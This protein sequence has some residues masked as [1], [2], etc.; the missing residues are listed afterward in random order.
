[1]CR[2]NKKILHGGNAL[3]KNI[4]WVDT[5]RVLASLLI[6]FAHFF[7]CDGFKPQLVLHN[8]SFDV[9]IIGVFL[10]FA[11]SGY[12]IPGSLER[13][14]S[15]CSFYKRK[16]VRIIMPFVVCYVVLSSAMI[17]LGI[18]NE[19]IAGLVPLFQTIYGAK[20]FPIILGMFPVDLNI[21]IY[22]GQEF[23]WFVGEWFIGTLIWLYLLSP[24]LD[25]CARRAP[26]LSLAIS[27]AISF[28]VYHATNDLSL[29][30]RIHSNWG[31]FPVRVPEFLLGIILF[32]YREKIL[33]YRRILL[34]LI[35]VY[36]AASLA[37]FIYNYPPGGAFFL[38]SNPACF[39]LTFPLIYWFF[40][41]AE[42][43]NEHSSKILD[44][45][46]GFNGISYAA[47]LIQHVIIY[48]FQSAIKF[49][50][51][52]SFGKVYVLFLITWT[53]ILAS[54]PLKKCSDVVENYLLKKS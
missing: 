19:R 35:T 14:K 31:L 7:M 47:M 45:F 51:L 16:L 21:V 1:M 32:I 52:H 25:K 8:I 5:I 3:K 2:H 38:V 41:V 43:L 40:S 9:A 46:N 4:A 28:A 10:F 6:I 17:V 34:P 12:L 36:V 20:Y 42:L 15:L 48:A 54:R 29:S 49:E 27:V 53:I 18:F 30:G 24:L 22:F 37:Y 39:A 26:I 33:P 13:S 23:K 50:D 11:M 44:W